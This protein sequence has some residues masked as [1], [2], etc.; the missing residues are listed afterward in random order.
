MVGSTVCASQ[1]LISI[2]SSHSSIVGS[3]DFS[4][5]VQKNISKVSSFHEMGPI[6]I[7]C[8]SVLKIAFI[9]EIVNGVELTCIVNSRIM[10]VVTYNPSITR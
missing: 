4:S 1:G 8:P 10:K 7:V 9:S 5:L 6:C 2:S 3:W